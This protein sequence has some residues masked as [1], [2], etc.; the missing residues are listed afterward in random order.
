[1]ARRCLDTFVRQWAL[2]ALEPAALELS[3]EAAQH[4]ARERADLLRLWQQRR[5]RAAYEADRAGRQY[6]LVEPENRLV[7]R[8]LERD[9]EAKLAAQQQL[10]EEY[11]RFLRQQP[12]GLTATEQEA[13]HRLAADIP[14]L[15]AAP[16]TTMAERKEILRQIVQRVVVDAHGASE[17]VRVVIEWVGG[18]HTE[19]EVIRPVARLEQLSY[20]P[21]LC[22]RVR[23]LAAQ[24]LSTA[25][26]AARLN[27]EGYRPP[28]RREQFR[29]PG[30]QDLLRRLGIRHPRAEFRAKQPPPALGE[31]EWWLADLAHMISMPPVTLYNWIQR[32]W[33]RARQ[34]DP[35]PHRWILWADAAAIEHLRERAQRPA[36]YYTRRLWINDGGPPGDR[37]AEVRPA[38]H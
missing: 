37:N 30:V 17:R 28:K 15:W 34:A 2:A 9:W 10:E 14:A 12:R 19:G 5:E 33:V 27:A 13:I 21:R 20:Y 22:E 8:Q 11:Q 4:L 32:G 23:V 38:S 36:G 31:H 6:R 3:L 35:P 24:G 18:A 1:M 7:A 29:T 26:I 16:T 25:T